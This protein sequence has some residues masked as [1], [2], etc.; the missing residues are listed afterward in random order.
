MHVLPKNAVNSIGKYGFIYSYLESF[1]QKPEK[2]DTR[3]MGVSLPTVGLQV[4]T[5]DMFIELK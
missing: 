3:A 2:T 1:K 5:H 4:N